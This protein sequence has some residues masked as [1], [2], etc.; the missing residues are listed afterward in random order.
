MHYNLDSWL[1]STV[2]TQVANTG[3]ISPLCH[4]APPTAE[5]NVHPQVH[6][7]T[8]VAGAGDMADLDALAEHR[9]PMRRER[10]QRV[11]DHRDGVLVVRL[12]RLVDALRDRRVRLRHTESL[13]ET[14][15]EL[16]P[17]ALDEARD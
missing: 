2:N 1:A 10:E 13:G 9:G 8:H 4:P 16:E 11:A 12:A 14:E 6:L 3:C 17:L 7:G 15:P 5:R